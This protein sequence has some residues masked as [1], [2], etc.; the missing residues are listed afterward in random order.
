MESLTPMMILM[1]KIRNQI[2]R[3]KDQNKALENLIR[4]LAHGEEREVGNK[5]YPEPDIEITRKSTN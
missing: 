2:R 1:K 3:K 4:A 5:H